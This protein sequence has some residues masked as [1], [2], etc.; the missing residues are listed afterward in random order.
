MKVRYLFVLPLIG[1]TGCIP[2]EPIPLVHKTGS[3]LEERTLASE[4]CEF[5]AIKE[6]PRAMATDIK[7][8][9]RRPGVLE[10]STVGGTTT[11]KE[12]GGSNVPAT[13][14]TYDA[15]A[16]VRKKYLAWCLRERGFSI[17]SRP[18]CRTEAEKAAAIAKSSPQAPAD[19]I[20]CVAS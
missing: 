6:I 8:A 1:L 9:Y 18:P 15:N 20:A 17:I 19:Q 16:E 13:S 14:T 7:G 11:C 4:L 12:V 2:A 5:E 10:C 3:T